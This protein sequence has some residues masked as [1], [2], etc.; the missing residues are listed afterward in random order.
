MCGNAGT[1]VVWGAREVNGVVCSRRL[2]S[3]RPHVGTACAHASVSSVASRNQSV[4][5]ASGVCI[6]PVGLYKSSPSQGILPYAY[7]QHIQSLSAW[8]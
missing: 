5:R 1:E 2:D 7:C 4:D 3:D 6:L 8:Q